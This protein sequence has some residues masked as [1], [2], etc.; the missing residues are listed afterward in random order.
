MDELV[1]PSPKLQENEVAVPDVVLVKATDKGAT[2]P[3][4]EAKKLA[5]GG[6]GI[7]TRTLTHSRPT[8]MLSTLV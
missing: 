2:P 8:Y 3:D 1:A 7:T 6:D 4:A 5:V